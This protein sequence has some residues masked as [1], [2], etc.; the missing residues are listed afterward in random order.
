MN[1]HFRSWTDTSDYEQT[2]QIVHRHFRF[3]TDTSDCA[4]SFQIMHMTLQIMHRH[5]TSCIDADK[6][7]TQHATSEQRG[8]GILQKDSRIVCTLHHMLTFDLQVFMRLCTDTCSVSSQN[9]AQRPSQKDLQVC[10]GP[11][12]WADRCVKVQCQTHS[13][14]LR[15]TQ[16]RRQACSSTQTYTISPGTLLHR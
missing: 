6:A 2:L 14:V 16:A 5:L 10:L 11:A 7:S 12:F 13:T 8:L 4:P 15:M 3:C 1:R 9:P